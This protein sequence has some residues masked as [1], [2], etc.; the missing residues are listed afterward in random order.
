MLL[1][2][3]SAGGSVVHANLVTHF[4]RLIGLRCSQRVQHY[5][6]RWQSA[7]LFSKLSEER[8]DSFLING[9]TGSVALK[10]IH[11]FLTIGI[12]TT[13][14]L[15]AFS[16]EIGTADRGCRSALG[17]RRHLHLRLGATE[18]CTGFCRP[19]ALRTTAIAVIEF[20]SATGTIKLIPATCARALSSAPSIGT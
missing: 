12:V 8:G 15:G 16:E 13:T 6:E 10:R 17:C 1:S 5:S 2:S 7:H 3:A 20:V 19:L 4:C 18:T 14:L 9:F 11:D